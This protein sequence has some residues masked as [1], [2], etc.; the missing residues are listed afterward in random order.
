M[1]ARTLA[2]TRRLAASVLPFALPIGL[3]ADLLFSVQ[4]PTMG[5]STVH[6]RL[7]RSAMPPQARRLTT[8]MG[9]RR[10][11]AVGTVNGAGSTRNVRRVSVPG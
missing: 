11:D 6:G 2:G 9:R 4:H 7:R 10:A 3:S 5:G 8:F 1:T